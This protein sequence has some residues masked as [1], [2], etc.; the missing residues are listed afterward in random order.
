VL[1]P[2]LL[3]D[4]PPHPRIVE[5]GVGGRFDLAEHLLGAIDEVDLLLVDVNPDALDSAPEPARAAVDDVTQ[6]RLPLYRDA[7]LIVARRCPAELQPPIARLARGVFAI[8][9]VQALKDEWADWPGPP[10]RE[11]S[12]EN[13][14]WRVVEPIDR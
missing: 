2:G 12:G 8:L 5:I 11:F 13:G 9:A 14:T 10:P 4:L 3:D 6:P 1:A 7:D